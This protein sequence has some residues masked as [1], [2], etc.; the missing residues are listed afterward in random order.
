MEMSRQELEERYQNA[1]RRIAELEDL[2]KRANEREHN[3]IMQ[4][5][6]EGFYR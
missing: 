2:L 1:L 6:R 4:V 5:K 3:V